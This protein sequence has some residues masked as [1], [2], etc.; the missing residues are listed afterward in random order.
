MRELIVNSNVAEMDHH[1]YIYK[2]GKKI[3]KEDSGIRYAYIDEGGLLHVT[4]WED[5]ASA[6]GGGVYMAVDDIESK[7]GL[8]M[9]GEKAYKIWGAGKN[10]VRLSNVTREKFY[11]K[12]KEGAD[13]IITHPNSAERK[14][15]CETLRQIYT[16]I[17]DKIE[18]LRAE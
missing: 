9:I 6:Y 16:A 3:P 7:N 15:A 5:D 4:K 1:E 10:W 13:K 2:E 14:D 17:D 8:P 11:T 12:A 18:E